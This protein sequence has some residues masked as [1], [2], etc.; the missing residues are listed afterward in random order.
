MVPL[1]LFGWSYYLVVPLKWIIPLRN[2]PLVPLMNSWTNL[3]T[4]PLNGIIQV[5][6]HQLSWTKFWGA[7]QPVSSPRDASLN[8]PGWSLQFLGA[9]CGYFCDLK[10]IQRVHHWHWDQDPRHEDRN[11]HLPMSN[12]SRRSGRTIYLT[13]PGRGSARRLSLKWFVVRSLEIFLKR[14]VGPSEQSAKVLEPGTGWISRSSGCASASRAD[15]V[16]ASASSEPQ[17]GW[18]FYTFFGRN[19]AFQ[20]TIPFSTSWWF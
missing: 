1:I 7:W 8:R 17:I 18:W 20:P 2:Y 3:G 6:V 11:C 15:S 9:S 13:R 4:K 14:E 10:S 19:I 12:Y 5:Y 16:T